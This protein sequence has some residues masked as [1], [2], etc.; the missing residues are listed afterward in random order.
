MSEAERAE[1]L[2]AI[3]LELFALQKQQSAIVAAFQSKKRELVRRKKQI[4]ANGQKQCRKCREVMDVD[5]F[6]REARYAD[7]RRP[8]CIECELTANK[9]RAAER[10]VLVDSEKKAA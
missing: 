1:A 9:K 7:G 2:K 8:Y 3:Q 6:Y 10:R 5:Q 4:A